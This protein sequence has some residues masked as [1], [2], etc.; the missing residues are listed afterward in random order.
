MT[1][2]A[3]GGVFAAS[4]AA[5]SAMLIAVNYS[6]NHSLVDGLHAS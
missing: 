1:H 2:D 4:A 3:G 5:V 6:A